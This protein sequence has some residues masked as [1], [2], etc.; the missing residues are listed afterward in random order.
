M[1]IG[2]IQSLEEIFS[3]NDPT[4]WDFSDNESKNVFL[5]EAGEALGLD[6]FNP[7]Q[8]QLLRTEVESDVPATD[9]AEGGIREIYKTAHTSFELHVVNYKNP[10]LTTRYNIVLAQQD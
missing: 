5:R 7:S 10:K 8:E 2:D 3:P 4:D 1:T 6:L 9:T